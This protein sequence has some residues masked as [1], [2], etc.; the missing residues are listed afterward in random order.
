MAS[1]A[2][3]D[4]IIDGLLDQGR[5]EGEAQGQAKMLMRVLANRGFTLS[6]DLRSRIQSCGDT[7]QLEAWLD[8]AMTASS[9][10][11]I[12]NDGRHPMDS[13]RDWVRRLIDDG[14]SIA[15]YDEAVDDVMSPVRP[16]FHA[17]NYVWHFVRGVNETLAELLLRIL[18]K[19]GFTVPDFVREEIL[20]HAGPQQLYEWLDAALVADSPE[21]IFD[22]D[23][24]LEAGPDDRESVLT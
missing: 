20:D 8:K 23:F 21:A 7:D 14:D 15:F 18:A 19:R 11:A 9:I 6:D 16:R 3:R 12:F 10:E 24:D 2:Y 4:E 5:A 22:W 13:F 1:P 17:E